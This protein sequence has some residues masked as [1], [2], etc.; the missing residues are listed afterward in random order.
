MG[1]EEAELTYSDYEKLPE[2]SPYELIGGRLILN[3]APIPRHQ[4][5]SREIEFALYAFVKKNG[6]G[7]VFYSPIDI[8]L[9][10]KEVYQPDIIFIS[11]ERSHIIGEKNITGP[12]DLVIEI[13]SESTAYNDLKKKKK[14]YEQSGVREYWI[15]DPEAS[16]IEVFLLKNGK[17]ISEKEY[18]FSELL[19]SPMF[20]GFSLSLKEVF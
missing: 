18:S 9:G 12:P 4:R 10:E 20:P 15:V 7:E 16:S 8:H 11:K 6:L 5:I 2:G 3:P 17:Y 13:L 14:V 19:Q 1:L